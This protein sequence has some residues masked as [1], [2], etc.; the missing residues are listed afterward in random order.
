MQPSKNRKTVFLNDHPMPPRFMDKDKKEDRNSKLNARS[1]NVDQMSKVRFHRNPV[2]FNT[3]NM[4]KWM[5]DVQIPA[6]QRELQSKEVRIQQMDATIIEQKKVIDRMTTIR[7]LKLQENKRLET[8]DQEVAL[9]IHQ[10]MINKEILECA[11][12]VDVALQSI[13]ELIEN[14]KRSFSAMENE[15]KLMVLKGN[16]KRNGLPLIE[17]E[18]HTENELD[19]T[20]HENETR[21]ESEQIQEENETETQPVVLVHDNAIMKAVKSS[22]KYK[23]ENCEYATNKKST[24]E[25]HMTETCKIR[26]RKGLLA[27]KN[28]ECKYCKKKM[29]HNGLR[30]HLRH[31]IKVLKANRKPK[32]SKHSMISLEEFNFY[33]REI[34]DSK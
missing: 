23:C 3:E 13:Q 29:H 18:S 16:D 30:S 22:K 28:T 26:R 2:D 14:Q 12:R 11:S 32:D 34:K 17:Q 4:M 9:S 25:T 31:F 19:Q 15:L 20:H 1:R 10:N 24:L 21:N 5:F 8:R 33:L 6:L 27:A 7:R